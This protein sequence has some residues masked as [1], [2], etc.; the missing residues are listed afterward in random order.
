MAMRIVKY[1][2]DHSSQQI[3]IIWCAVSLFA[4]SCR[5]PI[6]CIPVTGGTISSLTLI[7][8]PE[9]GQKTVQCSFVQMYRTFRVPLLIGFF[10]GS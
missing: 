2:Y 6:Y 1:A 3:G 10:V 8:C 4:V 5:G 7:S 9:F